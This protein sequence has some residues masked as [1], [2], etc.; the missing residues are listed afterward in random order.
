MTALF[1]VT[2]DPAPGTRWPR[3]A[4]EGPDADSMGTTPNVILPPGSRSQ[5]WMRAQTDGNAPDTPK[6]RLV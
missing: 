5:P 1:A 3:R 4:A 2:A 6:Y